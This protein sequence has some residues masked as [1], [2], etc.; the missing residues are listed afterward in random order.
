MNTSLDCMP[1]F[2][3]QALNA[4]RMVS[5]DQAV[6]ARIMRKV[7]PGV[8][9]MDMTQ[10]PPVMARRIHRL[11]RAVTGNGDPYLDAKGHQNAMGMAL[12]PELRE[13]IAASADPMGMAVR[14][15]TAGNVI[16]MGVNDS[17]TERDVREAVEDA[18]ARPLAG[19]LNVFRD[20]VR[21]AESVLYLADNAG[22]I[23]LDMLLVEQI[24]PSRVTVAVRGGPIINDATEA[25]AR[26]VGLCDIVDVVSN[27]S[28][29][30]GTLLAD[31]SNEFQ[32]RFAEADMIVAKGQG[33]FET[34][35]GESREVFFLFKA[36]CP[37]IASHIGVPIGTH[38][39]ARS[40]YAVTGCGGKL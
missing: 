3:R 33:N 32:Q 27:G 21:D 23:A 18:V 14:V 20:A 40:N 2:V 30:P 6:H 8:S 10:P 13:R 31:C 22:E 7:L 4:A 34:L 16:D 9:E 28:D 12:L 35:S 25:D 11:L 38:V 37:V 39:V 15:A 26:S 1:C 5:A 36:K 17:V 24:G 19:D 29:V